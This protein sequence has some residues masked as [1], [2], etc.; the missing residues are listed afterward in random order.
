[1]M[2]LIFTVLF[3]A[4]S[5]HLQQGGN[6]ME[7]RIFDNRLEN[8]RYNIA[9]AKSKYCKYCGERLVKNN[10]YCSDYCSKRDAAGIK[11][12]VGEI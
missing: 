8:Y 6:S 5:L 4:V 9:Y 12:N 1:M 7:K 2:N 3:S 11:R 10:Q